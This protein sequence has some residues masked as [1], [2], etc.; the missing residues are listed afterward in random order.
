MTATLEASRIARDDARRRLAEFSVRLEPGALVAVRGAEAECSTL[1]KTL[2][3]TLEPDR[4]RL[5]LSVHDRALDLAHADP[6]AVA[7]AR[8]QWFG[9]FDGR[10]RA[11]PNRTPLQIVAAGNESEHAEAS[12]VLGELGTNAV[13]EPVGLLGERERAYVALAAALV[14]PAL[15]VLLHRPLAG[16][17]QAARKR[18][19]AL[20]CR[21]RDAGSAVLATCSPADETKGDIEL[22]IGARP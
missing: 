17:E 11:L 18:A 4:G 7:W 10:L 20:V 3:R 1:I 21:A 5:V 13:A 14:R 15:I 2:C 16:L 12:R 19:L 6:R 22:A 9:L 8:R